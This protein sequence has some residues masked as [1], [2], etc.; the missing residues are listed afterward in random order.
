MKDFETMTQSFT[1]AG[2]PGRQKRSSPRP[3]PQS[4]ADFVQLAVTDPLKPPPT[5][6]PQ[7]GNPQRKAGVW[8]MLKTPEE[9]I[10][11]AKFLAAM[12]NPANM[13]RKGPPPG[14]P[15]GWTKASA[16]I[17]KTTARIKAEKLVTRLKASGQIATDDQQGMEAKIEALAIVQSPGAT[18]V[19]NK[20]VK[21]LLRHYHPDMAALV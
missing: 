12:R 7:P 16:A 10:A 20:Y 3:A 17:A 18:A 2:K 19:R 8:D 21:R 6:A 4:V 9:R 5:P 11:Q 13:K 1:Q 15:N 14:I